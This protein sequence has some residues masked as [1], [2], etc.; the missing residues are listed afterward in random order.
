MDAS[1]PGQLSTVGIL[2]FRGAKFEILT[3]IR[4]NPLYFSVEPAGE[5]RQVFGGVEFGLLQ[6][7]CLWV[8]RSACGWSV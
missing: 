7:L 5:V 3:T 2:V 4:K 8:E 1:L 6:L